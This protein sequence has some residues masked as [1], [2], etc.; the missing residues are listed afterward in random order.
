MRRVP[1][2]QENVGQTLTRHGPAAA[3]GADLVV[4]AEAAFEIAVREKDGT[5]T[6]FAADHGLFPGVQT[7]QR[8]F[9][10]GAAADAALD[11]N[12]TGAVG[13]TARGQ[14]LQRDMMLVGI[15]K[16]P[17][18]KPGFDCAG[19]FEKLPAL[20]VSCSEP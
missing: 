8:N 11:F 17:A 2:A 3:F 1:A 18:V 13:I 14:G 15:K 19:N 5:S 4:L 6:G 9:H 20:N 12:G 10:V 16:T 7:H